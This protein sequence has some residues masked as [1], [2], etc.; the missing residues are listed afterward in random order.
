MHARSDGRS[1]SAALL[2]AA[3]L[4]AAACSPGG[5]GGNRDAE[6][7][8]IT[9]EPL[10]GPPGTE[11]RVRATG[12]PPDAVIDVGFGPPRAKYDLIARTRTDGNGST[13]ATVLVPAR[14]QPGQPYVFVM[15]YPP[16]F[17]RIT[18]DIFTVTAPAAAAPGEPNPLPGESMVP[19]TNEAEASPAG[20]VRVTGRLTDEGVECPALRGEDGKLY[21]LSGATDGFHTGDRVTVVGTLAEMS[22]CMQG[23]TIAVQSIEAA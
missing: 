11:V 3:L 19:D 15:A 6:R 17:L 20:T 1:R 12:F 16:T 9:V 21:T 23:T 8:A 2:A 13:A 7:P 5:G 10:T 18:S 4:L 14:A 22:I